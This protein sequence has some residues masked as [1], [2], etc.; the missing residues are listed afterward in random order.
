MLVIAHGLNLSV[1]KEQLAEIETE[2]NWNSTDKTSHFSVIFLQNSS[3]CFSE[4]FN[5]WKI[6]H[7]GAWLSFRWMSIV[8]TSSSW[9]P[10]HAL[11]R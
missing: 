1:S 6:P 11:G 7:P 10:R 8:G 3:L 2:K 5:I 4:H 9:H